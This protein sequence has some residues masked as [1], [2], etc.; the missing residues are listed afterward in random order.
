MDISMLARTLTLGRL[1]L[2]E[3]AIG[4]SRKTTEFSANGGL[5]QRESGWGWETEPSDAIRIN[6]INLLE[7]MATV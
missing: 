6:S 2:I 7:S 1:F 5:F 4:L 3:R